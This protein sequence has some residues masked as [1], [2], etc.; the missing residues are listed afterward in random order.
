MHPLPHK[1][2]EKY[3]LSTLRYTRSIGTNFLMTTRRSRDENF[4]NLID[5]LTKAN[6]GKFGFCKWK[7]FVLTYL[8]RAFKTN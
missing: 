1:S 5:A 6:N 7:K 2:V 8:I 3:C 4:S